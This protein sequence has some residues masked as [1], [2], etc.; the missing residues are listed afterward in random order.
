MNELINVKYL[1]QCLAGSTYCCHCYCQRAGPSPFETSSSITVDDP[2]ANLKEKTASPRDLSVALT[3]TTGHA[4]IILRSLLN[5]S[6]GRD[7][8]PFPASYPSHTLTPPLD[9]ASIFHCDRSPLSALLLCSSS[10]FWFLSVAKGSPVSCK[11]SEDLALIRPGQLLVW[12]STWVGGLK[13]QCLVS[14]FYKTSRK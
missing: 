14:D 12:M 6:L 8:L 10:T 9:I 5:T 2:T 1:A 7:T 3:S 11:L 4:Y 13:G